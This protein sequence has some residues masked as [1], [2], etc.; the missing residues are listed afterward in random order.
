MGAMKFLGMVLPALGAAALG[1][2]RLEK[3]VREQIAARGVKDQRVLEAMRQTPREEFVLPAMRGMAYDDHPL[4]I[5]EGQ[6]ISQPYIVAAMTEML[7][8]RGNEKVLEIGTGSGYQAAV[9]SRLCKMLYS[10]EIVPSLAVRAKETLARLGYEN[11]HVREGDGYLGW[12]G[13]APF[14]RILLTAAPAEVPPALIEQLAKGGRLVAPVGVGDQELI[15]IDKDAAG[16]VRY[17]R[18][19]GVRFVPMVKPRRR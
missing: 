15:V 18:G 3:M 12:P 16:K 13:E 6:T 8:L 1:E 7:H 11:V 17:R 4:P 2:T 10:I 5:G 9:L 19:F 14:D